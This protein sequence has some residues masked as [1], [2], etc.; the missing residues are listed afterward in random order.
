MLLVVGGLCTALTGVFLY[1]RE[2]RRERDQRRSVAR[3]C[4]LR[5]KL[6]EVLEDVRE[7]KAA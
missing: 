1:R 3:L 5:D 2:K 7:E 6:D 4:G